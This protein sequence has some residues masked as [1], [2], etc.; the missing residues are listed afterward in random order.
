MKKILLSLLIICVILT[1]PNKK[2]YSDENTIKIG[3]IFAYTGGASYLGEPERKTAQMLEEK[4]N[5]Q[6]GINGKKIEILIKDT[7]GN[8][9]KALN[10]IK[11]LVQ[12]DG[13]AAIVGPTTSGVS[14]AIKNEMNNMQTPL[15]SCAAAEDIVVPIENSKWIFKTPQSDKMAVEKIFKLMKE[16]KI[17]KIGLITADQGFGLGGAKQA[18]K[19]AAQYGI[20]IVAAEKYSPADAEVNTQLTKIKSKKPQ[21]ILCWD[22]DQG[23]AK[24]AKGIKARGIKVPV[25][26]SHGIANEGFI[27]AAGKSGDGVI[28]PCGRL[29][30]AE[31]LPKNH[32]QKAMLVEFKKDYFSKYKEEVNTF[33]GHAYDAIMILKEALTIAKSTDKSKLRDA[34][35]QVKKFNGTAG[36]FNFS[37]DDHNGLDNTSFCFVKLEKGKWKFYKD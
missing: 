33:A 34:I 20:E 28:L 26:M 3:A 29:V 8:P 24:V 21:A 12:K 31:Q 37:A 11:E 19:Y 17:S 32:P 15:I 7:A 10:A 2:L 22:T 18:E 23:A 25:F 36:A 5:K 6:G 14:L 30:I 13:V 4:I 35:E 9:Q 27:K 16:M 1:F